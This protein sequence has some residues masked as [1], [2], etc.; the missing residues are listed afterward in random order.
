[1]AGPF[2]VLSDD[3]VPFAFKNAQV[4]GAEE[5]ATEAY[6][7]YVEEPP[8]RQRGRWAFFNAN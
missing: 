3:S 2:L 6:P 7:R 8:T 1:M 4:Q 5:E